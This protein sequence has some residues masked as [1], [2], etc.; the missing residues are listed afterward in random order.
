MNFFKS[1]AETLNN[2]NKYLK[3]SEIPKIKIFKTQDYNKN[4]Y[5][6]INIIKNTFKYKVAIRSSSVDEDNNNQTN[7]GK[8]TSILNVK[9]NDGELENALNLV[10]K[11]LKD[12]KKNKFFVQSMAKN[13][14]LS[15]VCF[16][17][18]INNSL[19]GYEINYTKGKKTDLI[20]SGT[21]NGNKIFYINN[22]NYK[23]KKFF[24]KLLS[25]IKE[26]EKITKEKK[27]DIEFAISK[28]RIFILQVRK[29]LSSSSIGEKKTL[30]I[31]N[32][33]SK[34]INK[35]KKKTSNLFGKT[36]YFGVMPDWNPAEIIGTKPKPLSLSL[37][38]YLVTDNIWSEN[39]ENYGYN[40]VYPFHLL[41][42]FYGTPYVD[43]RIDFNSWIPSKIDNKLKEKIVNYYLK[44][45]LNNRKSHDKIEFE[46][47]FSCLGFDTKERIH[48]EFFKNG[49]KNYEINFFIKNLNQITNNTLKSYKED[50]KKI[51]LLKKKQILIDNSKIY[52]VDKIFWLLNDCKKFGTLPF[53]GLA[54]SG[55]VAIELLNSLVRLKII[56]EDDKSKFLSTINTITSKIIK[57]YGR[58][59]KKKFLKIYGHLRPNTYEISIRNY[60][61]GFNDYFNK[62]I[63]S[64]KIKKKY[65]KFSIK[66]KNEISDLLKKNEINL[67]FDKFI[68]FLKNSIEYREEAKFIFTKSI[69]LIF[70]NIKKISKRLKINYEQFAYVDINSF[71]D[72]YNNLDNSDLNDKFR[73]EIYLNKIN[74]DF[75]KKIRLPDIIC[76]EKD[77]FINFEENAK[78]NFI[79]SKNVQ[80]EILLLTSK[81]KQNLRNKIIFIENA[82]PGYDFIFNSKIKGL[83]TKYGGANSHM[84]IRCSELSIPAAIGVGQK[85]F[86]ELKNQKFVNLNCENKTLN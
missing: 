64:Q 40:N 20:T 38:K 53:A 79:G 56:S 10:V 32:K 11:S 47:I 14:I 26:I 4:K 62:R 85:R 24:N 76:N 75:N 77:I 17:E 25:S 7:A 36:T 9:L 74:Y 72:L 73:K 6:I 19:K 78:A 59:N 39:R 49:F 35:L 48:K 44:K 28:N 43:L 58:F 55:F 80:S 13:I 16:T 60:E 50:Y 31:T 5:K 41:S 67:T 3:K 65:F 42:T 15:G 45:F 81:L 83:I 69:D 1:K 46:I 84:A 70:K 61:D 2:L 57:D 27:L 21:N 34:K 22:K 12:N 63:R 33:L 86:E 8:Y 51:K 54:R 68:E 82:D 66:Q 52:E 23:L 37:Y 29:L 30:K 71:I 18:S